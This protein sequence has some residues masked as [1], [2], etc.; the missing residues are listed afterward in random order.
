MD[1]IRGDSSAAAVIGGRRWTAECACQ[2][3]MTFVVLESAVA[4]KRGGVVN[5]YEFLSVRF[6]KLTL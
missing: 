3:P 1:E 4:T 6:Q 5:V 2:L